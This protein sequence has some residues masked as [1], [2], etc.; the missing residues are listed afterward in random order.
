MFLFLIFESYKYVGIF[1]NIQFL[2]SLNSFQEMHKDP[3]HLELWKIYR[4]FHMTAI[5]LNCN[6]EF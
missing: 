3:K 5:C 6:T 1:G 4:R 2:L